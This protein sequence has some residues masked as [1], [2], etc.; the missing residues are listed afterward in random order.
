[1]TEENCGDDFI[2][3]MLSFNKKFLINDF[4]AFYYMQ[5]RIKL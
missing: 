5:T 1:M 4:L 2:T 3:N